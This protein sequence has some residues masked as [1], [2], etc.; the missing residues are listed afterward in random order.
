MRCAAPLCCC[1]GLQGPWS[2]TW[3]ISTWDPI[4]GPSGNWEKS[5]AGNIGPS[6]KKNKGN[7]LNLQIF[8][9]FVFIQSSIFVTSNTD[10]IQFLYRAE[11]GDTSNTDFIQFLYRAEHGDSKKKMEGFLMSFCRWS[12]TKAGW[13]FV[14][15]MM[16]EIQIK[17]CVASCWFEWSYDSPFLLL[18]YIGMILQSSP[19]V[20]R[21]Y[22]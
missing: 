10:F 13:F 15:E 5:D 21:I 8:I 1:T 17:L 16:I 7:I 2:M 6:K 19:F 14:C 12:E 4:G 20:A 11:H 22:C 18:G 9:E 3:I